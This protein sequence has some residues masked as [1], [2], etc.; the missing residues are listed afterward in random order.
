MFI[1]AQKYQFMKNI[2]V[3]I[4]SSEN[5]KNTLQYAI[6]FAELIK[7]D[8]YVYRAYNVVGK[9]GTIINLDEIIQ[10][11]TSLYVRT[12]INST[13]RKSVSVKMI[14]AKGSAID[15]IKTIDKKLGID[16]IILGP[17]SNSVDETV[18]LGNTSGSII[19][20]TEIPALIVP[21]G[22]SFKPVSNILTAFR[23][24]IIKKQDVL[25][26]LKAFVEIFNAKVNLLLVKTPGHTEEDLVLD[27]QLKEIQ[28]SLT[29]TENATTYQGVL[30]HFLTK[31]PDMLCVFR[32][33]RGFFKKL[34]EKNTISKSEF[35][36]KVP[37]LVLSGKQ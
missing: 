7:A 28:A 6:D 18:F 13:D 17:R 27:Q 21:E 12:V 22:Y 14:S 2:L 16:L 36:C 5:A 20:Q 32:R 33:K 15:S 3:P 26:P 24:G 31:N 29:V 35:D 19:K 25:K 1:F 9:A 37:L 11:E 34:L 10:R 8:I 30:T 23:S 4:G